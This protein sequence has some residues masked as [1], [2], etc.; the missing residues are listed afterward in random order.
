MLL[1]Q[2]DI[3][4]RERAHLMRT[5]IYSWWK[6]TVVM[7]PFDNPLSYVPVLSSYAF[8]SCFHCFLVRLGLAPL[9]DAHSQIP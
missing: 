8:N 1:L 4:Q 6:V 3:F 5:N 7:I 2:A 9:L